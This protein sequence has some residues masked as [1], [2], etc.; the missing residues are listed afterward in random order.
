MSVLISQCTGLVSLRWATILVLFIVALWACETPFAIE[1]SSGLAV[2]PTSGA[3]P[4]SGT[5]ASV[6]NTDSTA[7]YTNILVSQLQVATATAFPTVQVSLNSSTDTIGATSHST[8]PIQAK[9]EAP[10]SEPTTMPAAVLTAV[11]APETHSSTPTV[12][13][14]TPAALLHIATTSE[15]SGPITTF[16]PAKTRIPTITLSPTLTSNFVATPTILPVAEVTQS[17]VNSSTPDYKEL[18]APTLT[19]TTTATPTPTPTD[20]PTPTGAAALS[21]THT[22]TPSSTPTATPPATSTPTPNATPTPT[23]TAVPSDTHTPTPSSTPTA[24]PPATHTPVPEHCRIKGNINL[25]S[26]ERA[27]RLIQARESGG[28]AQ[29]EKRGRRV[30]ERHR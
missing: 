16:S 23:N 8:G 9:F 21:D 3:S 20:I 10:G 18:P 11:E 19:S 7:A 22:P 24:T 2:T 28:S 4:S 25:E 17:A 15:P 30:G 14:I 5:T 12:I 6:K 13:T 27:R 1:E 26:G 29:S